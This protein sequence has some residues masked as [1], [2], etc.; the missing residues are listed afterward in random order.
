MSTPD[1]ETRIRSYYKTCEPE[2]SARLMLASQVLLDDA[3]RR[4]PRR[5]LWGSLRLTATLAAAAVL[6]AVL[7]LPRLGTAVGPG[8][9][10]ASPGPTFDLPA[11]LNA[12]VDEAGLMRSGGMWAVQGSYFLTSTNNGATWRAGSFPSPGGDPAVEEVFVLD[13]DHAWAITSNG[14]NGGL[15]SPALP[16]QL[17]EINRTSDGGRTWQSTTVSGNYRCDSVTISFADAGHGFIMCSYGS[18]PGPNGSNNEV[19]TQAKKG[20]GTVLRTNDGGATWSVAGSAAGLGSQF[21][22]ADANTL[23]SAPDSSSS[24]L[25]GVALM[26]SRDAGQTWSTVNLPGMYTDPIP[27]PVALGVDGPVF[28]DAADGVIAVGVYEY[29]SGTQPAVWFYRTSDAGRSWTVF[30]EP[31]ELPP[32]S[33]FPGAIAGREWATIGFFFGLVTS[34][35]FG[36]SWTAVPGSGMPANKPPLWLDFTDKDHGIATVFADA[37]AAT[38]D[39]SGATTGSG[40]TRVLMQTSDG[41]RTWHPANFGD[42]RAKLGANSGDVDA[43]KNLSANY[44]TMA[45]KDPPTAWNMLSS[46]S[47][48]AFGSESAFEAAMVALGTRT[49]YALAMGKITNSAAAISQQKLGPGVWGDLNALADLSRAYAVAVTFPGSSEPPETLVIAPLSATGDWRVWVVTTP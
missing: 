23:W 29:N 44:E 7:V 38:T 3:R 11:A 20:S 9:G 37:G 2:D 30:K 43:V 5:L 28:W 31:T 39:A 27:G 17:F 1:L 16:G 10:T 35:D 33:S 4:S 41:G 26:V 32:T 40:G 34:S 14:M 13:P 18:M 25:T 42:A 21:T 47:Q 6:F 8:S 15:A 46:Y 12:Q 48:R 49:N 22:A 24:N 36:A 19:R 45:I